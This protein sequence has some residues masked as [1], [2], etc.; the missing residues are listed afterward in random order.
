M[1]NKNNSSVEAQEQP[2]SGSAEL[3]GQPKKGIVRRVAGG[4]AGHVKAK[5]QF[6]VPTWLLYII[7]GL[8]LVGVIYGGIQQAR[9]W[10]WKK[11]LE[12]SQVR[13]AELEAEKKAEALRVT[14]QI[15]T[16]EIKINKEKMKDIDKKIKE[17]DKKKEKIK[18]D[19]ARMDGVDL[20]NAFRGEGLKKRTWEDDK[21]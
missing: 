18:K 15:A 21:K 13:I 16:G 9:V 6:H 10:R 5:R 19:S 17:I 12:A 8:G 7:G 3:E 14:K 2:S 20:M 1:T 11:L 4:V